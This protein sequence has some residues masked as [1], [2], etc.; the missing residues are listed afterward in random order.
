MF[1]KKYIYIVNDIF[2]ICFARSF[3]VFLLRKGIMKERRFLFLYIGLALLGIAIVL[4]VILPIEQV[5]FYPMLAVAILMKLL[6]LWL[7]FQQK[8]IH[9]KAPLCFILLGVVL[10]F[11]AIL[12]KGTI[13]S[14]LYQCLFF[15]AIG[16]KV[17]GLFLLITKG[18]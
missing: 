3:Y 6:F 17:T 14:L 10:I 7:T 2:C 12:C 15:L 16:L 5:V 1:Q 9:I 13:S 8:K 18:K 11:M 4:K